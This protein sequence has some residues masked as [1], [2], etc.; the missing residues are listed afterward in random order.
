MLQ[1]AGDADAST[2]EESNLNY[3]SSDRK[4]DEGGRVEREGE[5]NGGRRVKM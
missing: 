3:A 1:I 2:N 5:R 4:E